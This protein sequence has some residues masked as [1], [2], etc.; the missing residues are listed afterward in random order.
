M[1]IKKQPEQSVSETRP[2]VVSFCNLMNMLAM[3]QVEDGSFH[4]LGEA[5]D[6]FSKIYPE[7]VQQRRDLRPDQK[8]PFIENFLDDAMLAWEKGLTI[9]SGPW[10]EVDTDGKEI[11]IEAIAKRWNSKKL[12]VL[13]LLGQAYEAQRAFLQMGREN[14]LIRQF[15]EEE[16]RKRTASIRDREEEIAL[17]LVWAAESRDGGE[18]GAHIRR[19]GLYSEVMAELLGW[20]QSQIDEIRIAATM[21]DVGKI[22]IPDSILRKPGPLTAVEFEIMKTHTSIGGKILEGSEARLLQMARD[23]ALCHHEKWDGTGYPKGLQGEDIPITARIVA[24]ADVFDALIN[25]RVYKEAW[26]LDAVFENLRAEKGKRFDPELL[27]IFLNH[28]ERFLEISKNTAAPM[29]EGFQNEDQY[30]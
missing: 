2:V 12:L 13:E 27:E 16:V 7:V 29:L 23:I 24:I 9:K 8:F 3:E 1:T 22:G 10:V 20:D 6:D 21:H 28:S 18:T 5:P 19:L 25:K 14:V 11:A 26:P 17:R 15:L 30:F 4:L